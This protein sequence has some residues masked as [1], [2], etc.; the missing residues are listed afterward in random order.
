MKIIECTV[1]DGKYEKDDYSVLIKL[2]IGRSENQFFPWDGVEWGSEKA[3]NRLYTDRNA[4][5]EYDDF[6][7]RL[8]GLEKSKILYEISQELDVD[9]SYYFENE[10]IYIYIESIK[11]E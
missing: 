3:L 1:L 5:H 4:Q 2:I 6:K 8:L 7:N 9:Q 10:R 11:E